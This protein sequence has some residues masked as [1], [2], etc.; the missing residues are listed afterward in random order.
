MSFDDA[1]SG[2]DEIFFDTSRIRASL[3]VSVSLVCLDI[4]RYTA[5]QDRYTINRARCRWSV[6]IPV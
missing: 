3:T 1:G 5:E 6:V 4:V 2:G